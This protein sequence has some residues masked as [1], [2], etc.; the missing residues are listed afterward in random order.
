M[1]IY[2]VAQKMYRYASV[3]SW[4]CLNSRISSEILIHF[5]FP[6]CEILHTISYNNRLRYFGSAVADTGIAPSLTKLGNPT[7]LQHLRLESRAIIVAWEPIICG[8]LRISAVCLTAKDIFEFRNDSEKSFRKNCTGGIRQK[9]KII[10]FDVQKKIYKYIGTYTYTY[11]YTHL[12]HKS[13]QFVLT[14]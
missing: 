4:T 2:C 5:T 7:R 3:S 8:Y 1:L 6:I 13:D 11:I 10:S 14:L 12:P 9:V